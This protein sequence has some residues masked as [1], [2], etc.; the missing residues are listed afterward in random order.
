MMIQAQFQARTANIWSISLFYIHFALTFLFQALLRRISD[1]GF[2][3]RFSTFHQL[4]WSTL[5]M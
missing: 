2:G 3:S 1:Q 4:W 5:D